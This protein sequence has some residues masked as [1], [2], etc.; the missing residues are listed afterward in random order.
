MPVWPWTRWDGNAPVMSW[1]ICLYFGLEWN[2]IWLYQ[3][4]IFIWCF[5]VCVGGESPLCLFLVRWCVC[6][7]S[8]ML[9]GIFWFL[10]L[11]K[12]HTSGGKARDWMIAI[13]RVRLKMCLGLK[14]V[15][16]Q[17]LLKKKCFAEVKTSWE[18]QMEVMSLPH[19]SIL[20]QASF[21][22]MI[23]PKQNTIAYL[24]TATQ[25]EFLIRRSSGEWL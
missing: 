9:T 13:S 17:L 8:S 10:S 18:R 14:C 3:S 22:I 15:C 19:N 2:Y 21:I 16:E 6:T 5:I 4:K 23:I 1:L 20:L 12:T 25:T 7:T 11:M 24:V